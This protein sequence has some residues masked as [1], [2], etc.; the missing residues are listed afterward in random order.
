[1][2][3]LPIR[4]WLVALA[5]L[6][7]AVGTQAQTLLT[8]TST[9]ADDFVGQGQTFT[10]ASPAYAASVIPWGF[11]PLGSAL[12][13][14]FNGSADFLGLIVNAPAGQLLTPG[15]TYEEAT[16]PGTFAP[17]LSF[18]AHGRGC[19]NVLSRF[20][21]LDFALGAG[22][23][24]DRL[25]IDFEQRCERTG[26]PLFGS[27]RVNSAIP[28]T[29]PV[30]AST[31]YPFQLQS[32][33]PVM[34]GA[35][36]V[37]NAISVMGVAIA[38][39]IS[40]TGGEYSVNGGPYTSAPGQVANHDIV[41]VRLVASTTGGA[42]ARATLDIG[43]T[44]STLSV[45]TYRSG[46]TLSALHFKSP[47]DSFVG[48]GA[49]NVY[50]SPRNHFVAT[51]NANNGV[52]IHVDTADGA[53]WDL[54][55]SMANDALPVPGRYTGA[56]ELPPQAGT[57][58]VL[59]SGNGRACHIDLGEFTIREASFAPNGDVLAFA[60]DF[61]Q[62]CSLA[63]EPIVGEIRYNSSVP[64]PALESGAA[65][66]TN[67]CETYAELQL[68]TDGD[69]APDCTERVEA[70]NPLVKDNDVFANARLFA[71]Q[72]YRDFLGRE[73]DEAGVAFWANDIASGHRTRAQVM[74][75]FLRSAEF[76]QTIA[77]L[78]RLYFTYFMRW[79]DVNGLQFWIAQRR[80]GMSVSQ[81]ADA[82]GQS[83][84]FVQRYGSLDNAAYVN[85]V[86]RN[87]L[88]RAPD[89]DGFLFWKAQLDYGFMT[90]TEMML[91]V[92]GSPEYVNGSANE[93]QVAMLYYGMLRREPDAGGFAFWVD[94]LDAGNSDIAILEGFFGSAEYRNRFF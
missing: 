84:E 38:V 90:R 1:M 76:E 18:G 46:E 86:Y 12:E 23:T 60:A 22:S 19:S 69:G 35:T 40:I 13:I 20:T 44:R 25:A 30:G 94:F 89:P 29:P 81:I 14:D 6:L 32:Q 17:G 49:E 26:P 50:I 59:F 85:L 78:V 67:R 16:R 92:S 75:I 9:S 10:A 65:M 55:V 93:V 66:P 58:G 74:R 8:Y 77:P 42:T 71:R 73:G 3:K 11:G 31:P 79:P 80:A 51:R 83:A 61:L 5:C 45:A 7:A 70:T 41:T 54:D 43:G 63:S 37:S 33:T 82:F 15:L 39:P 36:V 34:G 28:I 48:E 57:P 56:T 52:Q 87:V 91:R 88:G 2:K 27:V 68:D 24:I 53:W 64:F 47:I 72:Q 62:R 21:V 4:N